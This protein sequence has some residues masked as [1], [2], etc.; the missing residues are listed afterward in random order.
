MY[1]G[2][3]ERGGAHQPPLPSARS[4]L[5]VWGFKSASYMSC[6][7]LRSSPRF[8]SPGFFPMKYSPFWLHT[9]WKSV[10]FSYTFGRTRV[11]APS[12]PYPS[13]SPWT[14][15]ARTVLPLPQL[16]GTT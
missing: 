2:R 13:L 1:G 14:E 15:H 16:M 3:S 10:N 4:L 5:I 9:S 7:V 11:S 12:L 8:R 6:R